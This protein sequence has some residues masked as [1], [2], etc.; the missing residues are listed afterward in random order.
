MP[1]GNIHYHSKTAFMKKLLIIL[2]LFVL[3]VHVVCRAL[4]WPLAADITKPLLMPLLITMLIIQVPNASKHILILFALLMSWFGDI[5]LMFAG[6]LS[7]MIGLAFFLAA[8][9]LYI[10]WLFRSLSAVPS[11]AKTWQALLAVTLYAVILFRYLLP[12]LQDMLIPVL[13]YTIVIASMVIVALWLH[14]KFRNRAAWLMATGAILFVLSD[15]IL[16][17]NKFALPFDMADALVM[18]TYGIAQLLITLGVIKF[19]PER[20]A[21]KAKTAT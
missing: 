9:I 7:F 17:I 12:H 14:Q 1:A 19:I 11:N 6:S 10:T 13:V 20:V 16:A 8:H 21:T 3:L 15:S 5:A 2:Y 18:I 4:Q